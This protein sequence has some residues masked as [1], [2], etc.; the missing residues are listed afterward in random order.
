MRTVMRYQQS[1][2]LDITGVVSEELALQLTAHNSGN[3][4]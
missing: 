1:Q 4:E 2:G 3:G